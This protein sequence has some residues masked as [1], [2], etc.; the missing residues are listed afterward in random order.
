MSFLL[1][2]S[3]RVLPISCTRPRVNNL[4]RRSI[5]SSNVISKTALVL[6]SSGCLGRAVSQHL[7]NNLNLQV[8]GAD[9]AELPNET[10]STLNGFI[11]IPKLRGSEPLAEMT[12]SL[13]QGAFDILD[14]G[15]EI[16]VI[17]CAS[18]GWQGDPDPP[19][20]NSSEDEFLAGA[21]SYGETIDKMISMNLYPVLSAGYLAQRFMAK[22]GEKFQLPPRS[23]SA[24]KFYPFNFAD[25]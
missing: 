11:S 25:H 16:D 9:V 5:S 23:T 20:R 10:D 7:S 22:E 15:E 6:G 2:P 12:T 1:K 19:L 4:V 18:G 8:I 13:V 14:E 3:Q 24:F 21:K 17:V